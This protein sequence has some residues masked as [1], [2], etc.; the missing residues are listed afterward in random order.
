MAAY[1]SGLYRGTANR[2]KY[3]CPACMTDIARMGTNVPVTLLSHD[4][5]RLRWGFPPNPVPISALPPPSDRR[6]ILS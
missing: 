5:H 2:P 3:G 4:N 1:R 6:K